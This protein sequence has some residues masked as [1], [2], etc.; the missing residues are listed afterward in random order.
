MRRQLAVFE[1]DVAATLLA[2]LG[3]QLYAELARLALHRLNFDFQRAKDVAA[4]LVARDVGEVRTLALRVE[5]ELTRLLVKDLACLI[6]ELY[7]NATVKFSKGEYLDFLGR[8]FRFQEAVLRYLAETSELALHTD[9]DH[10][11]RQFFTF[12]ASVG[13]HPALVAYLDQQIY[14]AEKLNWGTPYIPCLM[15]ILR[16]LAENGEPE[17]RSQRNDLFNRLGEIHQLM[18]LRHKSPLGHGF[19]G[20]SL[21]AI[22]NKVAGFSPRSLGEIV[23]VL[24]LSRDSDNPFDKVNTLILRALV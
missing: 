10:D 14:G 5:G 19:D 2:S 13:R 1:Y 11:G 7:H 23:R 24:G 6:L 21:E 18:P 8:L 17:K 3:L 20:V 4:G 16:Y 12:Q 15:A 22:Q 9:I